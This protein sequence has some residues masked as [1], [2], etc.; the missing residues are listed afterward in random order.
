[1]TWVPSG[2]QTIGE[3]P[4]RSRSITLTLRR[5]TLPVLRTLIV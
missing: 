2:G 3:I 1:M 4:A 5:V